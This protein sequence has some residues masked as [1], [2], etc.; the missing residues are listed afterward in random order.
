ML[1]ITR[2]SFG[3][4]FL[5]KWFLNWVRC[6]KHLRNVRQTAALRGVLL[7]WRRAP[8]ASHS[9]TFLLA[10]RPSAS[11]Q[12]GSAASRHRAPCALARHGECE[13]PQIML[14]RNQTTHATQRDQI[15]IVERLASDNHTQCKLRTRTHDEQLSTV[16]LSPSLLYTHCS[17]SDSPSLL[18]SSCSYVMKGIRISNMKMPSKRV[19]RSIDEFLLMILALSLHLR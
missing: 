12:H 11:L 2:K 19:E 16:M 7:V 15:L 4:W 1:C 17:Y 18:C 3:K 8:V 14:Q 6:H 10:H 9:G 13:L 5:A